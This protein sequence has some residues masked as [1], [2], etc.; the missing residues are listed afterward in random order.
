MMTCQSKTSCSTW[1]QWCD[2]ST[3][4][5]DLSNPLR[6]LHYAPH[7][8]ERLS[9]AYT[10]APR[11]VS[12]LNICFQRHSRYCGSTWCQWCDISTEKKESSNPLRGLHC[13]PHQKVRLAL[14][15]PYR[16]TKRRVKTEYL[17]RT[18]LSIMNILIVAT[19]V[20][21]V[22]EEHAFKAETCLCLY[23]RQSTCQDN[24]VVPTWM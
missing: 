17:L 5:E 20:G 21:M 24:A 11:D 8:D 23:R 18:P 12:K 10:H 15:I 6:G 7:L 16:Y 19:I 2:T 9:V 1:C 3:E 22:A 14:S 4:K 13:A